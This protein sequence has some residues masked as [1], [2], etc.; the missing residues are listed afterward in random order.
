MVYEDG[1]GDV[2]ERALAYIEDKK[3]EANQHQKAAFANSV[4]TMVTGW[5][6][7]YGGPSVREHG[8]DRTYPAQRFSFRGACALLEKE[9][10][11]IFGPLRE[12]H[13]EI[14]SEERYICFDDDPRDIQELEGS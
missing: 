14:W 7:G 4:Q 2:L 13:R 6:G 12:I 5:A 10:G 8:V 3:P 9:D 1:P 11:L